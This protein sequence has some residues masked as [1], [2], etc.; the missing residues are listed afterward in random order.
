LIP[1]FTGEAGRDHWSPIGIW[2]SGRF[3]GMGVLRTMS[4]ADG[5]TGIIRQ[6]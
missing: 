5:V 6:E 2:S 3:G 1:I 4:S